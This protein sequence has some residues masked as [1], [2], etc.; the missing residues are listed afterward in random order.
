M[1]KKWLWIGL[2][3]LLT[4]S[5]S[6][7]SSKVKKS[8]E[9][10]YLP[11]GAIIAYEDYKGYKVPL[12]SDGKGGQIRWMADVPWAILPIEM[13]MKFAVGGGGHLSVDDLLEM[14]EKFG[15]WKKTGKEQYIKIVV[16]DEGE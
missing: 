5:F 15:E 12:L 9:I 7:C 11:E 16:P 3:A 13:R 4:I 6:A 14:W 8:S 2:V 10:K 1:K